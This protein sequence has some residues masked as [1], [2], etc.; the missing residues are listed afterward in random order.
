MSTAVFRFYGELDDFLP[1]KHRQ[2][3]I[4]YGFRNTPAAKLV[5]RPSGENVMRRPSAVA[6]VNW[7]ADVVPK[8]GKSTSKTSSTDTPRFL[9]FA[10]SL[11]HLLQGLLANIRDSHTPAAAPLSL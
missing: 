8:T 6:S 10:C 7:S 5:T 1:L 3:D 9:I 2:C 11:L 4:E